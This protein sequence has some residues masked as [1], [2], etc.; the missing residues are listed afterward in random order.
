MK[1]I[2]NKDLLAIVGGFSITGVIIKEAT[3]LLRFVYGTGQAFG[4]SLRRVSSNN[5]CPLK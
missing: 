3:N 5:L 2:E 1:E 4:S